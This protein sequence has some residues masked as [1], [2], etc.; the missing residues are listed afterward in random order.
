MNT[1]TKDGGTLTSDVSPA[2]YF[3]RELE[4]F[5]KPQYLT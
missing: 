3:A 4:R 1:S 5:D 2:V